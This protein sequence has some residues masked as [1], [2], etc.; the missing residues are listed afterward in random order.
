MPYENL[1]NFSD[2]EVIRAKCL[3]EYISPTGTYDPKH[4]PD[5]STLSWKFNVFVYRGYSVVTNQHYLGPGVKSINTEKVV[6]NT[7]ELPANWMTDEI[8]VNKLNACINEKVNSSACK[9]DNM[10]NK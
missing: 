1:D 8:T 3:F 9:L 6:Y 10:Y 2:F 4:I 7:R 5:H